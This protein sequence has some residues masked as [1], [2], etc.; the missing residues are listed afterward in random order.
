LNDPLISGPAGDPDRD[1]RSNLLEWALALDPHHPDAFVPLLVANGSSR[2]LTYTR[3]KIQAGEAQLQIEWSAKLDGDWT[4]Q[5]VLESSPV[6]ISD[7]TESMTAILPVDPSGK[8]FARLRI[9]RT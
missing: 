1:G 4:S 7:T 5:G 2:S 8:T 3:R 6:S 9:T